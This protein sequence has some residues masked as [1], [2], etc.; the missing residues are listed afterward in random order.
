MFYHFK[1]AL[2]KIGRYEYLFFQDFNELQNSR[3]WLLL[4]VS[5]CILTFSTRC[6]HHYQLGTKCVARHNR[7]HV[8]FSFFSSEISI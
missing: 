6:T 3:N 8:F 4:N 5:P 7:S 2:A 1:E